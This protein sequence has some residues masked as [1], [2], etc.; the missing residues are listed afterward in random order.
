MIFIG[1]IHGQYCKYEEVLKKHDY[2]DSI[3][4]GDFGLGF[5]SYYSN[6]KNPKE[7]SWDSIPHG[8]HKFIRGNHDN[9]AICERYDE[10]L[11]DCGFDSLTGI[12][13][14]SGAESIDRQYRTANF[15]WWENEELSMKDLEQAIQLAKDSKPEIV[16]SHDGPW[17]I[18]CQW[19]SHYRRGK[20][21]RTSRA[22]DFIQMECS[23]DLYIFGHH[24]NS[25]PGGVRGC[26]KMEYKEGK[27]QFIC[28][29][30]LA[31]YDIPGLKLGLTN[32]LQ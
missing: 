24:H 11:G 29:N 3:Q 5:G 20:S 15:D 17:S 12:F 21:S 10:Y 14:L 9:P 4:L 22:M 32:L 13:W 8:H 18:L 16:I 28:L 27:R 7:Y 25:F 1:D 31:V 23:A 30:E 2:Q 6:P 26:P 19:W